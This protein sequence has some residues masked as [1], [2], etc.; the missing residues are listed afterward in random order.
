MHTINSAVTWFLAHC[1]NHRN[2]SR[3][4]LKAYAHDLAH[5]RSFASNNAADVPISYIDRSVVQ[6]WLACMNGVKPRTIRR[7]LA[8]IKSMFS[9]LERH[10]N[11]MN[12]PLAGFR[13][14][15]KVGNSLPRTVGRATIRSR[16]EERRVGKECR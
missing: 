10:G 12:N 5:L 16:S 4:T 11:L 6:R 15:V 14:E 9:C 7:R 1:A 13:S 8:T 3:H 2:L